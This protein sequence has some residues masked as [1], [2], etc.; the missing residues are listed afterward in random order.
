MGRLIAIHVV[1]YGLCF[2]MIGLGTAMKQVGV[3][4]ARTPKVETLCLPAG[5]QAQEAFVRGLSHFQIAIQ[6]EKLGSYSPV[7]VSRLQAARNEFRKAIRARLDLDTLPVAYFFLGSSY[8]HG[9]RSPVQA[10]RYLL[11]CLDLSPDNQ[12]AL[13]ALAQTYKMLG[14]ITLECE[15]WTRALDI[16]PEDAKSRVWAALAFYSSKQPDSLQTAYDHAAAAVQIDADLTPIVS[17]VLKQAEDQFGANS[18]LFA[19]P[20][21]SLAHIIDSPSRRRLPEQE[22]ERYAREIDRLMG[23]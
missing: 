21:S 4:S 13:V 7:V 9:A 11:R 2:G 19:D 22:A 23:D 5:L 8:L 17:H 3:L 12:P 1:I 15:T 16:N 6:M 20:E 14:L 10:E 18:D